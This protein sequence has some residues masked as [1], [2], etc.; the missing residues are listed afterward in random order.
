MSADVSEVATASSWSM[1]GLQSDRPDG[2]P[3]APETN[4]NATEAAVSVTSTKVRPKLLRIVHPSRSRLVDGTEP[5]SR[6][7]LESDER[8]VCGQS[9]SAEPG[10][11]PAGVGGVEAPSTARRGGVG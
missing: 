9:L 3:E 8:V 1:L 4:T 5:Y 11:G 10:R 2:R 7:P 6:H